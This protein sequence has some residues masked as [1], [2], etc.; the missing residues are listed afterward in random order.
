MRQLL[1]LTGAGLLL[2]CGVSCETINAGAGVPVPFTDNGTGAPVKVALDVNAK[3][4]PPKFC[5]GLDVV[6][7]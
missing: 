5:I 3:L 6:G 7:E 1:L 4:L 2:I